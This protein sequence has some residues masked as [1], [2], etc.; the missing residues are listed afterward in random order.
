MSVLKGVLYV[1]GAVAI[2]AAGVFAGWEL[3]ERYGAKTIASSDDGPDNEGPGRQLP[4][5]WSLSGGGVPFPDQESDDAG[6]E[7]CDSTVVD[8]E[9]A[10]IFREA[11][12]QGTEAKSRM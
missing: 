10:R 7:A 12:P 1:T 3:N 2:G 9:V 6:L 5:P 8:D 4:H 11:L